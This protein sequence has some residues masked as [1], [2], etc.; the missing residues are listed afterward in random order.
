MESVCD[1]ITI[2]DTIRAVV[3]VDM[4][5][6]EALIKTQ[7]LHNQAFSNMQTTFTIFLV[8]ISILISVITGVASYISNAKINKTMKDA[9]DEML[10]PGSHFRHVLIT[11]QNEQA[12]K[13]KSKT[14]A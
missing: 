5:I 3:P 9:I 2:I 13:A 7:E 14:N 4:A 12:E 6:V 8:T 11:M 10:K 1:T